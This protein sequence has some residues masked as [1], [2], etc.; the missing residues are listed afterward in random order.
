MSE[1]T[2]GPWQISPYTETSV[3]GANINRHICSTGGPQI[4]A[5][6]DGST[7]WL[8]ENEANARL[9]AAA[10]EM[11]EALKSVGDLFDGLEFE[12][13]AIAAASTHRLIRVVRA[14]IAKAEGEEQC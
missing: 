13:D 1:H 9:I 5:G 10:P 2:K 12:V 14:A 3:Q 6:K 8:G 11:L 4:M 7:D